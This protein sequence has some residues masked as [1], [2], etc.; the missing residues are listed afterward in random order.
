MTSAFRDEIEAANARIA[1]LENEIAE[2][3]ARLKTLRAEK[4]ADEELVTSRAVAQR[5]RDE[6]V[7]MH[8]ELATIAAHKR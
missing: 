7:E 1:L 4:A 6:L 3:R 5:L 8:N 2:L